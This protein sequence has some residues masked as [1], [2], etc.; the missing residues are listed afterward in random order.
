[1]QSMAGWM[2]FTGEP[3]GPPTKSG[4]S[5]V[6][7]S[8]GYVAAIAMLSGLWRARREGVGCDCDV[9]LF[10]TA[11][12]E[13]I[14]I[15]TWAATMGYEPRRM[16]DSAHPSIVPFQTFET[17]DGWI[18]VACAKQKFWEQLCRAIEREDLLADD[19]FADFAG[20]QPPPRRAPRDPAP[21]VQGPHRVA[22]AGAPRRRRCAPRPGE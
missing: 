2:S 10:E 8:G 22:V 13:L 15:G 5:L 12:H 16:P 7:L 4:L 3:D 1:M 17:A 18:V 9:S 19:R 21:G 11:L 14:Y 6:D 20:A